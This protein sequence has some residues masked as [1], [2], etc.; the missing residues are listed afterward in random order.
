MKKCVIA[1]NIT[2][3]Y[4]H[5]FSEV[6]R[7]ACQFNSKILLADSAKQ[8]NAKSIMGIMAFGITDGMEITITAEGPDEEEALHAMESLLVRGLS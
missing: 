2:D 7:I 1:S 5:P 8:V 3:S 6:V 4:A